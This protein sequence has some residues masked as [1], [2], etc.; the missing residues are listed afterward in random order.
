MTGKA[1]GKEE[2]EDWLLRPFG[3]NHSCNDLCLVSKFKT[4]LL[5]KT[6]FGL[7]IST[8]NARCLSGR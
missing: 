7:R 3:L 8:I 1:R 5:L 2:E 6:T 4:Y